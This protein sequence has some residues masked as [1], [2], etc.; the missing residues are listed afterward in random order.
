MGFS[1]RY[2]LKIIN[3]YKFLHK[4]LQSGYFMVEYMATA[5]TKVKC[6]HHTI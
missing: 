3:F 6:V 1:C 4:Y 5:L 2:C